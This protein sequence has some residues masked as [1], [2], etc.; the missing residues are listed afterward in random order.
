MAALCF[1]PTIPMM[2]NLPNAR[3]LIGK[4]RKMVGVRGQPFS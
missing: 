3:A 1:Q 2:E 4:G